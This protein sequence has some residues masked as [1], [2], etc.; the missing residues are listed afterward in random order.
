MKLSEIIKI[1]ETA[2]PPEGAYDWDNVTM[3]L[4]MFNAGNVT[5]IQGGEYNLTL[6][7]L[8]LLHAFNMDYEDYEFYTSAII[9]LWLC[10]FVWRHFKHFLEKE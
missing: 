1:I 2:F 6:A 9:Y 8:N 5:F 4:S 3:D 7:F 10:V